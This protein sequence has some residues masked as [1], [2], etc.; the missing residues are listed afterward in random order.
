MELEQERIKREDLTNR[1]M[2]FGNID[3]AVHLATSL[4]KAYENRN[5]K[6]IYSMSS[7][8]GENVHSISKEVHQEIIE[9]LSKHKGKE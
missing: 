5:T 8:T 2:F 9:Q 6:V 7:V 3:E 4:P 1:Q